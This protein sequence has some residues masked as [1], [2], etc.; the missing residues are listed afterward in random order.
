LAERHH[1]VRSHVSELANDLQNCSSLGTF[2]QRLVSGV[3]EVLE[4]ERGALFIK[5]DSTGT[6][7]FMAGYGLRGQSD[8]PH[9]IYPSEGLIG[10]CLVERKR[11][12]SAL[13]PEAGAKHPRWHLVLPLLGRDELLGVVALWGVV[14]LHSQQEEYLA[15][16]LRM[17][18]LNLESLVRALRTQ[19][20]LEESQ[21]QAEELM[22]SQ[23]ALRQQQSELSDTNQALERTSQ[24]KSEFLANM[25]HELRTPLNSLLLLNQYLLRNDQN[26]LND[27]QLQSLSVMQESG[28]HLLDLINN[29]LDLSRM[30]ADKM[31]IC[32]EHIAV[33]E[34][35]A[36]LS[37]Q[38]QVVA[39]DRGLQWQVEV[40]EPLPVL[41]S[42]PLRLR[43]ILVN[44][45]GNAFKFTLHG[46]VRLKV[47][48]AE[49]GLWFSVKDSGIGI[50]K[51]K[52]SRI[53][54]AFEQVDGSTARE[55]G[56]TGLGLA[57]CKGL[58]KRL[59]GRLQLS[60]QPQQ[61]SE[62]SLWLPAQSAMPSVSIEDAA[63]PD[64]VQTEMPNRD[65]ATS[66]APR[67]WCLHTPA[68]WLAWFAGWQPV[69]VADP[70]DPSFQPQAGDTLLLHLSEH[71]QLAAWQPW[72]AGQRLVIHLSYT[73]DDAQW[74]AL[75]HLSPHLVSE[76][77]F[78]QERLQQSLHAWG[79]PTPSP[80]A[81]SEVGN[82]NRD[83][84]S[85]GVSS[86]KRPYS[87]LVVDDDL[88]NSFALS[89]TLQSQGYNVAM[90]QD[91]RKVI[92]HLSQQ[93]VDVLLLDIM[94]PN[95][96][97]LACLQALR[98]AGHSLPVIAVTAK[99]MPGDKERCLAAGANDYLTKPLSLPALQASLARWLA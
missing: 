2:C 38:F 59:G 62:F 96:D 69:W 25:S 29:I 74:L 91:A 10:Q 50:A 18:G 13:P 56:G 22:A 60:S 86:G 51:D 31:P 90:L 72:L 65:E 76:S 95:L 44:L 92:Q 45:L 15:A 46:S 66:E 88:R 40:V 48:S 55:Y 19:T 16:V 37:R 49:E 34:L 57:L 24:Y 36:S 97:G 81:S 12:R 89:R 33:T 7:H 84:A 43:Q 41:Y 71:S 61:G 30:D 17:G 9:P 14:D 63:I 98:Q 32:L 5:G 64:A 78:N 70:Q 27:E 75:H 52:Q 83:E 42:D 39:E 53:F 93:P 47:M 21:A 94:M 99:A 67:L 1:W 3:A 85:L 11:L 26:N 20:L 68:H 73:P 82:E 8:F 28:G 80:A 4:V 77:P 23:E 6:L 87:L 79:Q 58:A 54:E 35:V